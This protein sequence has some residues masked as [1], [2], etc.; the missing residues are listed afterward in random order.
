[1]RLLLFPFTDEGDEESNDSDT[2]Q[3]VGDVIDEETEII[4]TE[5]DEI[6]HL[7]KPGPVDEVANSPGNDEQQS[8]ACVE[9]KRFT[10]TDQVVYHSDDCNQGDAHQQGNA[11]RIFKIRKKTETAVSYTHLTL[12]TKRIV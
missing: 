5:V 8:E 6:G 3:T 1:M 9:I 4:P 2:D 12:P 7:S 10:I 11:D